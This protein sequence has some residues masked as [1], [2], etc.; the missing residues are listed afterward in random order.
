MGKGR[1]GGFDLEPDFWQRNTLLLEMLITFEQKVPQRS[2]ASQNDHKSKGYPSKTPAILCKNWLSKIQLSSSN[3][4][5]DI[6]KEEKLRAGWA[7]G[8]G[9]LAKYI[10]PKLG[11]VH[12]IIY[13]VDILFNFVFLGNWSLVQNPQ[14]QNCRVVCQGLT[15]SSSSSS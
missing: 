6:G 13:Q 1:K 15:S 9:S 12:L 11:S 4:D 3:G 7:N 2:D 10:F 14:H 8:N 5:A